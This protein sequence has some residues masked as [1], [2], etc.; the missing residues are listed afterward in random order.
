M[1]EPEVSVSEYP[2]L[3][4]E[5]KARQLSGAD[6]LRLNLPLP[7]GWQTATSDPPTLRSP[8]PLLKQ[9]KKQR[10]KLQKKMRALQLRINTSK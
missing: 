1:T 3:T 9:K 8:E 10:K 5:L 7:P 6:F 4:Q 2:L